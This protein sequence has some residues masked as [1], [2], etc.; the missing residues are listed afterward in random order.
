MAKVS[1]P[2]AISTR[3]RR[4]PKPKQP[5]AV[6]RKKYRRDSTRSSKTQQ[7]QL[8]ESDDGD[9][10]ELDTNLDYCEVCL[11]AGDLVCCDK[12][13]RS[14]HL[15]CLKMQESDLPEG[16]WQCAECK[17]PSYF[18]GFTVKV[19]SETT[20][21]TKCLAI[22]RCLKSHPFSK[23]FLTPVENVPHYTSLVEKPMDLS[24][25]ERKLQKQQYA[26]Q[27]HVAGVRDAPDS[28]AH[29]IAMLAAFAHDVRL[30]WSNCKFFNDDGSGITRAADELAK[31][32]NGLYN[33][34]IQFIKRPPAVAPA[35]KAA[36]PAAVSQVADTEAKASTPKPTAAPAPAVT[37]A[38]VTPQPVESSSK[39]EAK[40][41]TPPV[42]ESKSTPAASPATIAPNDAAAST[43]T[44]VAEPAPVTE[45]TA[46]TP[47]VAPEPVAAAPEK[48]AEPKEG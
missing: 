11:G 25:I 15:K 34:V 36:P 44:Q 26:K 39:V 32:F 38:A 33:D 28:D 27:V 41:V 48:T 18:E 6:E 13:P 23:P 35:K 12:C 10:S 47:A 46:A 4:G 5:K 40:D 37:A 3:K 45:A 8:Q 43:T 7:R 24:T 30:V 21:A 14:F 42:P 29:Q 9:D 17:K 2:T 16:D 31:G 20:V 22:V 1:P 19:A